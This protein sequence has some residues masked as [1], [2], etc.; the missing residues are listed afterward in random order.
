M[1]TWAAVRVYSSPTTAKLHGSKKGIVITVWVKSDGF[2]LVLCIVSES[3]HPMLLLQAMKLIHVVVTTSLLEMPVEDL[4]YWMGKFVLEAQ[5][6][7]GSE[8]LPK[9]LYALVCCFKQFYEANSIH[10][11][12]ALSIADPQFGGF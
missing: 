7:D 11:I 1:S 2:H 4:V 9:M 8:Y 12:N 10:N 6:K 3:Y 5:K